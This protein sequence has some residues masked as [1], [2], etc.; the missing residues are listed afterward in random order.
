MASD[1]HNRVIPAYYETALTTKYARDQ[2]SV[3][4]LQTIFS[5]V[6]LDSGWVY[7]LNLNSFP[8]NTLREPVWRNGVS[9]ATI[10]ARMIK[11]SSRFLD[12]VMEDFAEISDQQ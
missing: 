1:S 5:N 8:Q 11:L 4:S 2:D 7:S 9:T 12:K 3:T 10:I 6:Y